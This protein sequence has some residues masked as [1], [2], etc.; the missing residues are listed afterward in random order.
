M[1][2]FF[3]DLDEKSSEPCGSLLSVNGSMLV[4][5]ITACTVKGKPGRRYHGSSVVRRRLIL[6]LPS[7]SG[8]IRR[9]SQGDFC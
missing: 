3:N 8:G 1:I 7:S 2:R 9:K 5:S 4:Y 6:P